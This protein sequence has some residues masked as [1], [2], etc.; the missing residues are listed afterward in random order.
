MP[1]P[2]S[3]AHRPFTLLVQTQINVIR[4]HASRQQARVPVLRT[5]QE[6]QHVAGE[7]PAI[8]DQCC[9]RNIGRE[10]RGLGHYVI[11]RIRPANGK[12]HDR[13]GLAHTDIRVRKGAGRPHTRQRHHV[14]S[15]WG[16][17]RRARGQCGDGGAVIDLVVGQHPI[18]RQPDRIDRPRHIR[19]RRHRIVAPAVAVVHRV[20]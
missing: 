2:S 20:R 19:Y 16:H 12:A 10:P 17:A 8:H 13:H 4:Q 14:R 1:H 5:R 11:A 9:P 3:C 7:K 15:Q 18:D 6:I